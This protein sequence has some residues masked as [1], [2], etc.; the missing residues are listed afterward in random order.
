MGRQR[1]K[2]NHRRRKNKRK[3]IQDPDKIKID[4]KNSRSDSEISNSS[5][6]LGLCL[7]LTD[8][9][10][11]YLFAGN[12]ESRRKWN[13]IRSQLLQFHSKK[14]I[15]DNIKKCI[16]YIKRRHIKQL[17]LLVWNSDTTEINNIR[18]MI[19]NN[20]DSDQL[21]YFNIMSVHDMHIN[22]RVLV[23]NGLYDN[24]SCNN[25]EQAL[26]ILRESL[27][28]YKNDH[29]FIAATLNNIAL[30]QFEK[31]NFHDAEIAFKNLLEIKIKLF[32]EDAPLHPSL[33]IAY[34]NVAIVQ[35]KQGNFDGAMANY[36]RVLAIEQSSGNSADLCITYNNIAST[37]DE[38]DDFINAELWY[39]KAYNTALSIF[40]NDHPNVQLYFKH[41][42]KVRQ[43][44]RTNNE[45]TQK[46]P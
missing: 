26:K 37:Y 1:K 11:I 3:K 43:R 24:R 35:M 7:D 41:L 34:N 31:K 38:K 13:K 4:Y 15:F 5:L 6:P 33:A 36:E 12:A 28:D 44:Q 14:R 19:M 10:N 25:H 21:T 39:L 2:V 29:P 30:C 23:I 46:L 17:F 20:V 32:N 45:T 18:E 16:A 8:T 22:D 42:E 40:P 9:T 27:K